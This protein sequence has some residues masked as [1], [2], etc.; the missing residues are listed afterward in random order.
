MAGNQSLTALL[1]LI[2][3]MI[4][5]DDHTLEDLISVSLVMEDL[6][7]SFPNFL[8]DRRFIAASNYIAQEIL[9]AT[10]EISNLTV[11][12]SRVHHVTK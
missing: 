5:A 4:V 7:A 8:D 10:E 9:D 2:R 11:I 12:Y 3:N 1:Q 6:S